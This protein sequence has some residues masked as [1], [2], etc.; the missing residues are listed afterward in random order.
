M[1]TSFPDLPFTNHGDLN[2][3]PTH[4]TPS[5][6]PR[7]YPRTDLQTLRAWESFPDDIH[8]AIRS[9]TDS[10]HLSSTPFHIGAFTDPESV[11]NEESIR[12]YAKFALHKPVREVLQKLGVNG[13]FES[14]GGG[15]PVIVGSPD[16]SWI[17]SPECPPHPKLIVEYKMW[18][19]ADLEH[20]VAASDGA[21]R[22]TLSPDTLHALEQIYGY[23]TF[24]NNRFGILTNWKRALFLQRAEVAGRHTLDFYTI[25]LDGNQDIV[26]MLKAWVGMV[27]LAEADW[28]YASPSLCSAPPNQ[29]FGTSN[30]ARESQRPAIDNAQGHRMQPVNGDYECRTLDFRLCHFDLSTARHGQNGCV[31]ETRLVLNFHTRQVICKVVDAARYPGAV[32][33]LNAEV[34]A[35]AALTNLQGKVIPTL[36]G[37]YM[38]WGILRLIALQPVGQAIAENEPITR[39]LR[40]KMKEALRCIHNAGYV[41]GDVARRNFCRTKS[42]RIF[43]VD[44]E[45]CR[46]TENRAEFLAEMNIVDG[47]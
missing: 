20:V 2:L 19:V 13:D 1:Q 41:H 29:T 46:R 31:V 40:K 3:K 47:W 43:L 26:S 24:N 15:N 25:E 45:R 35:Y 28:F 10:A 14:P 37:F 16:F 38:V 33:L 44:L 34:R 11:A 18:W 36:Y 5:S 4:S 30:T 42:G 7:T 6:T 23:M 27:L 8:H 9:A 39:Q 21:H 17:V 32:E 22:N 12:A